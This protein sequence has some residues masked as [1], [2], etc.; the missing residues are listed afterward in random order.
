MRTHARTLRKDM[1]LAERTIWHAV[2]A[3]RFNGV[4]FRRQA[5]I[6]PY[7]ADFISHA[8]KLIIEIDG[9]QH[10]EDAHEARDAIRDA[11]LR[12]RGFRVLRF[13]NHDVMKNRDGVLTVIAAV[14]GEAVAP[15]LPSPAS[16]GGREAAAVSVVGE[17]A[18][19]SQEG[20]P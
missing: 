17:A 10:F 18:A 5:P 19:S 4:S 12:A 9:G 8:A 16:G 13:N 6:G 7:I 20:A 2:R 14:L 11:Y 1:T 15:S 3:H